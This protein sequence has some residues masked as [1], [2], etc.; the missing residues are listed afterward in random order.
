MQML[1]SINNLKVARHFKLS[2]FACPCCNQVMLH[3]QLL[4]KLVELGIPWK[5]RSILP[6]DIVVLNI[7]GK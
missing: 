2:E 3:P 1:K 5:D 6:P 7:T 4:G